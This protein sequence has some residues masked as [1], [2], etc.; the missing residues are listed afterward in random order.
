[1]RLISLTHPILLTTLGNHSGA[2]HKF[3]QEEEMNVKDAKLEWHLMKSFV[4]QNTGTKAVKENDSL[5]THLPHR[6][7]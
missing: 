7:T 6:F 2:S 1:M 3:R 4:F 5:L